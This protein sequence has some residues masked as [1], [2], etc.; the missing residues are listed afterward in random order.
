MA[1][2][3][4]LRLVIGADTTDM[5]KG[6]A[7]SAAS[8]KDLQGQ[9]N[10][11]SATLSST[12]S[13]ILGFSG[14]LGGM[15]RQGRELTDVFLRPFKNV[16]ADTVIATALFKTGLSS[17]DPELSRFSGSLL[18][19]SIQMRRLGLEGAQITGMLKKMGDDYVQI[20]PPM[21]RQI[22][23]SGQLAFAT[24]SLAG[25]FGSLSPQVA[26]AAQSMQLMTAGGVLGAAIVAVTAAVTAAKKFADGLIE[27]GQSAQYA[28]LSLE[29]FQKTQRAL[30]ISGGL[31]SEKFASGTEAI[32]KN[33]FEATRQ[34]NEL[35]KFLKANNVEFEKAGKLTLSTGDAIKV[36][37]EMIRNASDGAQKLRIASAFGVDRSWILAVEQGADAIEDLIKKGPKFASMVNA[38]MIQ[39]AKDFSEGWRFY[40]NEALTW[41]QSWAGDAID[42]IKK[43]SDE[44]LQTDQIKDETKAIRDFFALYF[45]K[46]AW[47]GNKDKEVQDKFDVMALTIIRGLTGMKNE[48]IRLF[49]ETFGDEETKALIEARKRAIQELALAMN[50]A[51]PGPVGQSPA[52]DESLR[53]RP[54]LGVTTVDPAAERAETEALKRRLDQVKQ[55]IATEDEALKVQKERW[56]KDLE[57][58]QAAEL[59]TKEEHSKLKLQVEEKFQK[60]LEELNFQKFQESY[61]TETELL[62]R[63]QE[64]QLKD[65]EIFEKN[66]TLVEKVAGD[67][68]M[69][70]EQDQA[71]KRLQLQANL[72]SGLASIVDTAM[73]QI[74]GIMEDESNKGFTV[75]KA[76]A[77]ATALV[78]GFEAVVSAYAFGAKIGGPPLGI[79]MAAIAAAGTGAVIAKL[80]GVGPKSGGTT[81]GAVGGGAGSGS[82]EAASAQPQGGI[83]QTLTVSGI[84]KN[85]WYS[86]E[87]VRDL[88]QKLI[89]FQRDGGKLVLA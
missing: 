44:K 26:Q 53:N 33:L 84:N 58:F 45:D 65:L 52:A 3:G 72:Y 39:K 5:R 77:M 22:A 88:A 81:A 6:A 24:G 50:L 20:Q 17:V 61:M 57:K 43:V 66:K 51:K 28:N 4:T 79:A 12:D 76:V 40:T 55:M 75:M 8:M 14:Q 71:L 62:A 48:G 1:D 80:A 64:K 7:D 85:E 49:Q 83:N 86:G 67:T 31:T 47:L 63:R 23:I 42:L 18:T 89:A 19:N 27:L 30:E 82:A 41:L 35:S 78:K 36:M 34:E 10:Q 60:K 73:G 59:I 74:S 54:A 38:E 21:Q 15:T 87:M 9:L 69:R 16:L 25:Q 70:L 68:R 29:E 32:A 11:L 37:A 2:I 56:L 46:D 13:V